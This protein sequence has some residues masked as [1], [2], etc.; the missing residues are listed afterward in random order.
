MP[1]VSLPK[2]PKN[3]LVLT[4]TTTQVD[5]TWTDRANN[6]TK[7]VVERAAG[8][9]GA[10]LVWSW[11]TVLGANKREYSAKDLTPNQIYYFRVRA[12]N[13][14]GPSPWS[15]VVSANTLTAPNQGPVA[16]FTPPVDP[17]VGTPVTLDP[18]E[19]FDPD[20][21]LVSGS[22]DWGDGL[23]DQWTG[24][25]AVLTHQYAAAGT[26]SLTLSVTDEAGMS[27]TLT[28]S[29]VVMPP[30]PLPPQPPPPPNP[31]IPPTPPP[32]PG[33]VGLLTCT[34]TTPSPTGRNPKLL[35]NSCIQ[36]E[37][38]A[39]YANYL[40]NPTAPTSDNGKWMKKV[41][42][43]AELDATSGQVYNSYGRWALLAYQV[44]GNTAYAAKA[45]T[46]F[47]AD[48][49]VPT[50]LHVTGY[51]RNETRESTIEHA[52]FYDRL[53]P[54]LTDEERAMFRGWLDNTVNL[55]LGTVPGVWWNT[56][57]GDS[58][59]AC[60]HFFGI[61]CID[62]ATGSAHLSRSWTDLFGDTRPVGGLTA[63]A[64]DNSTFRN[65]I[66][67]F[68]QN[69]AT[70]GRWIEAMGSYDLGTVELIL[71]G[72]AA[73]LTA[74]GI[75]YFPEITA[76]LDNV[77]AGFVQEA[78]PDLRNPFRGGDVE[79]EFSDMHMH[80]RNNLGMMLAG[81]RGAAG[82]YLRQYLKD[83]NAAMSYTPYAALEHRSGYLL[84]PLTISTTQ[85]WKDHF[86]TS[87]YASGQGMLIAR[88][89]WSPTDSALML[90]A[91][92]TYRV[93]HGTAMQP[94]LQFY[95]KGK[96]MVNRPHAYGAIV[97][98]ADWSWWDMSNQVMTNG[99]ARSFEAGGI[100]AYAVV[101]GEYTYGYGVNVGHNPSFSVG[102]FYQVITTNQEVS[103]SILWLHADTV[104]E[105]WR[106]N[107]RRAQDDP[108]YAAV[109]TAG[110]RAIIEAAPNKQWVL[111]TRAQPTRAGKVLTWG[112]SGTTGRAEWLFPTA[113]PTYATS[114]FPHTTTNA[115][116]M[117]KVSP[118]GAHQQWETFL[119][120][121]NFY[122][123][124]NPLVATGIESSAGQPARG[125][126]VQRTGK[127]DAVVIF[128]AKQGPAIETSYDA[129]SRIA[130][131][132][133]K[134]ATVAAGRYITSGYTAGYEQVS[135]TAKLYL[136]DL[137]PAK[138][139]T[140]NINGAGAVALSVSA[141]GVATHS[142]SG[143]GAKSVVVAGV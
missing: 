55:I 95:Y 34:S 143:A 16:S 85:E 47:K 58:D 72:Y 66:K 84:P 14:A 62:L 135:A 107:S 24:P 61:A 46:A 90:Y 125:A 53:Y 102:N 19:S 122:E 117:T 123:G 82:P 29:L 142:V 73:V 44:T 103:R 33:T 126:L 129:N 10:P 81:L 75:D 23:I 78:T 128:S 48:W 64:A 26:F 115:G 39:A 119:T 56:N 54:Y 67:N 96:W 88:S 87:H 110:F 60:G 113:E 98:Q 57:L 80:A 132:E 49:R 36:D 63:T 116:Y 38:A 27:G 133:T 3:L 79:N 41:F 77:A 120:C 71:M 94:D 51:G 74:T 50:S 99:L 89:G 11:R 76:E 124:A 104:L 6:E 138:S 137:D 139:W 21:E 108:N 22:M 52:M 114:L 118:A 59:E 93:D 130:N 43:F 35:W 134:A 69:M 37:Y 100:P 97:N 86:G 127:N 105:C 12:E 91:P 45:W 28:S 92:T 140:I 42:Q 131:D 111:H 136:V 101:P 106:V 40:A 70:G 2:A 25:P 4:I 121:Y 141:M 31:P 109:Y 5:L 83:L 13:A 68:W 112:V 8:S 32:A 30:V 18:R 15:N 20:G 65:Q 7:Y 1:P 9:V 17:R